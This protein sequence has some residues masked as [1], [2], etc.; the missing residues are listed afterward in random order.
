M[1]LQIKLDP[2]KDTQQAQKKENKKNS[3]RYGRF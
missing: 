3:Y 1:D 2:I